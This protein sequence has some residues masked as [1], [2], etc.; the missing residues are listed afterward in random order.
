MKLF[1]EFGILAV[2]LKLHMFIVWNLHVLDKLTGSSRDVLR[3]G[4]VSYDAI[5]VSR[6]II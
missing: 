4:R 6:V 3:K 2:L 1:Q 5:R